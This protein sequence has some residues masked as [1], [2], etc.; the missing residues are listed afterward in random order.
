MTPSPMSRRWRVQRQVGAEKSCARRIDLEG[1]ACGVGD[2]FELMILAASF[3]LT[4]LPVWVFQKGRQRNTLNESISQQQP[5]IGAPD[6]H[7]P[8]PRG[9]HFLL[10]LATL[11][12]GFALLIRQR[13]ADNERNIAE[14][15]YRFIDSLFRTGLMSSSV[16]LKS[17]TLSTYLV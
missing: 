6:G 4:W 7:Q 10:L 13:P 1:R 12:K 17:S 11:K 16:Q 3:L 9:L 15:P 2:R 8:L 5:A 14:F